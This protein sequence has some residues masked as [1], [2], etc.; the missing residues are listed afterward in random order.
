[1]STPSGLLAVLEGAG[2]DCAV[3]ASGMATA[4]VIFQSC[5]RVIMCWC[6]VLVG[7][8]L[9]LRMREAAGHMSRL[10]RSLRIRMALID[11]LRAC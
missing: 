10:G 4:T 3:F 5:C 6:P 7:V 8:V 11:I 9:R 1:M 2:Y